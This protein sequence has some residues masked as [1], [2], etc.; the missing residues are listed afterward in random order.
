MPLS[1]I[2]IREGIGLA[3]TDVFKNFIAFVKNKH[4]EIIQVDSLVLGEVEDTAWC[5]NDDMGSFV[6]LQHLLLLIKGLTSKNDLGS[7]IW[8]ELRKSYKFALDL[9][10]EL[11]SMTKNHGGARLWRVTETVEYRKYKDG[12]FTH[13]R[14]GLA[15]DVHTHY[16]LWD[17]LLLN[18]AGMLKAA[19][20]DR[21]LKFGAQNHVLERGGVH[22][23]IVS[24]WL[25]GA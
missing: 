22:T 10:S 7:D 8:H 14:N 15:E 12:C 9:V 6:T 5:S 2:F 18:I 11:A 4:F 3:L 25:A 21:L 23:N 13:A 16:C 17:A 20:N 24:G 1:G 19:I